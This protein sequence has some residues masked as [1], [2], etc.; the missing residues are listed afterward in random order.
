MKNSITI[1]IPCYNE[2]NY[3]Y[4]TLWMISRQEDIDG[5]R[6]LVADGGST[7]RTIEFVSKA[8]DDFK[9][10]RIE[11]IDGGRVATGRNKGAFHVKTPYVLFMDADSILMEEDII[12]LTLNES[13]N[14]DLITCKQKS[15]TTSDFKSVLVY[16]L[17]NLIRKIMPQTFLRVVTFLYQKKNLINLEDLMKHLITRKIFGYQN[18]Y[19]NL[20]L[21]F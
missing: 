15:L 20:N 2:Q 3:I 17:F 12:K 6:I 18:K 4:N 10:L 14:F 7:D 9:N 1:V 8:S 13:D 16:K 5:V 11:L 21:K 19:Q